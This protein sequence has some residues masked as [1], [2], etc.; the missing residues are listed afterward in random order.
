V[1]FKHPGACQGK[2]G[3]AK[4]ALR[5]FATDMH[6]LKSTT[7]LL[8][9]LLAIACTT[10]VPPTVPVVSREPA[11]FPV[12]VYRQARERGERVFAIDPHQSQAVIHV[13]RAGQLAR[14]GHDHVVAARDIHGYVL[15]PGDIAAARADL[16]VVLD[17][18]S[19]DEPAL[20]AE[21]GLDTTPSAADIERTRRNMLDK[22]LEAQHYP[23]ARL[24]LTRP[25]GDL[26]SPVLQAAITLHGVTRT[27]P[28][29]VQMEVMEHNL[30]VRGRFALYQTDFGMIPYSLLGG[31][32][33]VQDQV[34]ISFELF[35]LRF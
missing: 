17:S 22:T 32:L 19:V 12:E 7:P 20:R 18:L 8:V 35:G 2:L 26:P 13:Y 16:Y 15:V 30:R 27:V 28:V 33:A 4:N 21:A 24:H 23:T 9:A 14:L 25:Q 3:A 31:A 10:T 29:L 6:R 11:D 34:D 5:A 1:K